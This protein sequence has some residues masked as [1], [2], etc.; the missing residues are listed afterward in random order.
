MSEKEGSESERRERKMRKGKEKE[1][2][3]GEEKGHFICIGLFDQFLVCI[4]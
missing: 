3:R 2:G 4:F 1:A